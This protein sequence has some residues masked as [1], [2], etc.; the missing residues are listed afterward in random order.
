MTE[1]LTSYTNTVQEPESIG[2]KFSTVEPARAVAPTLDQTIQLPGVEGT[3]GQFLDTPAAAVSALQGAE[4]AFTA[5]HT[6][7]G[8]NPQSESGTIFA[9]GMRSERRIILRNLF[10]LR[11]DVNAKDRREAAASKATHVIVTAAELHRRIR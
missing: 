8:I 6:L 2:R 3:L 5:I 9:D 7:V 4:S 11:E 10:S 1:R